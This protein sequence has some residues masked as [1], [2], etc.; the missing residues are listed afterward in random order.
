MA[1]PSRITIAPRLCGTQLRRNRRRLQ[2]VNLPV[3]KPCPRRY[4][5]KDM[6]LRTSQTQAKVLAPDALHPRLSLRSPPC[7]PVL[8]HRQSRGANG[9]YG[10]VKGTVQGSFQELAVSTRHDR[11]GQTSPLRE[12]PEGVRDAVIST[13]P[14]DLRADARTR[15]SACR[16]V[17]FLRDETTCSAM[18]TAVFKRRHRQFVVDRAAD[19]APNIHKHHLHHQNERLSMHS[20]VKTPLANNI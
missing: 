12:F 15:T 17:S 3:K 20:S 18:T 10:A 2:D 9:S 19:T 11:R 1:T 5:K 13:L 14:S 16:R 4:Y 7:A 6:P 8:S